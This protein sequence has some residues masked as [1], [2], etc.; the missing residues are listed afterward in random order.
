MATT[1]PHAEPN[2]YHLPR[3]ESIRR[4]MVKVFQAQRRETLAF[5]GVKAKDEFAGDLPD[6][7]PPFRLGALKESER[8]TPLLELLWDRSGRQTNARIGLDPDRWEVVNPHTRAMI[9]QSSLAFCQETNRTTSL[10][11]DR[12]LRRTREELI[13][14]VVKKGESIPQLTKRVNSIFDSASK[15]RARAIAQSEA[16]RA[17]HAAQHEAARQSDIVAGFEW[18]LSSDACPLCHM[19]AAKARF[20]RLEQPFAIIGDNPH[21]AA[22]KYPPGHPHCNCTII[23]V[24]K[25]SISGEPEPEWAETLVQPKVEPE[26]KP[27][28]PASSGLSSASVS[29]DDRA[30]VDAVARQ[31]FGRP[32]TGRTLA[33]LAGAPDN[34]RVELSAPHDWLVRAD[35]IGP[36]YAATRS[37]HRDEDL[38]R[39]IVNN[40]SLYIDKAS[41]GKGLGAAIFGRQVEAAIKARAA[42]IYC[43]AARGEDMTGYLVWPLLGYDGPIPA[44]VLAKLPERLRSARLVS[45]LMESDAGREWWALHG[46]TFEAEFD[47][48]KGSRS[49]RVWDAYL[50]RKARGKS[51]EA[52]IVEALFGRPHAEFA[53]FTG[54][55]RAIAAEVWDSL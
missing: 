1:K 24:L 49:R 26:E 20:V 53:D 23:E 42:M 47:L 18:L 30:K 7:F 43:E 9:E 55:D 51:F 41:R 38:G 22:I 13:A 12:A 33:T 4:E 2:T 3:G 35:V 8:F 32:V 45:D 17:V 39:P 27:S 31:V 44:A 40:D 19:I 36:D 5:L 21:Y 52:G 46:T 37:F 15:S 10:L 28:K 11:L 16:S 48:A 34:A 54:A 50:A 14:G 6:S 25:S 29:F